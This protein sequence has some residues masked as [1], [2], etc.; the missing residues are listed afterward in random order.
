MPSGENGSIGGKLG[1]IVKNQNIVRND[2]FDVEFNI[3]GVDQSKLKFCQPNPNPGGVCGSDGMQF[4]PLEKKVPSGK[5][6]SY[7]NCAGDDDKYKL[8]NT[9]Y[10]ELYQCSIALTRN[11]DA[12]IKDVTLSD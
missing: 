2:F 12:T 10:A 8:S 11:G 3:T 9:V 6:T 5:I 4:E 1:A 7:Y